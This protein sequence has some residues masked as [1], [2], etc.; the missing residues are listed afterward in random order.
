M[1]TSHQ[2]IAIQLPFFYTSR[3]DLPTAPVAI[4]KG[5]RILELSPTA[6]QAGAALHLPLR[7]LRLAIPDLHIVPYV[8]ATY[9]KAAAH[10]YQTC[11]LFSDAVEPL[12]PHYVLVSLARLDANAGNRL[13]QAVFS[14][15]NMPVVA[16]VA[17]T[18]WLARCVATHLAAQTRMILGKK[19]AKTPS[20]QLLTVSPPHAADFLASLP[21]HFLSESEIAKPAAIVQQLLCLG[22]QNFGQLAAIP[23][24]D[25][26]TRFGTTNGPLLQQLAQGIDPTPLRPMC[27]PKQACAAFQALPESEGISD[28]T[29]ADSILIHLSTQLAAILVG[30]AQ[31]ARTI[32]LYLTYR[33]RTESFQL[34]LSTPTMQ[35][36]ILLAAARRLWQRTNLTEPIFAIKLQAEKL[37]QPVVTQESIFLERKGTPGG[38]TQAMQSVHTRFGESALITA[39]QLPISRREM[40]RALWEEDHL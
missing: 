28:A 14:A 33:H 38:L 22:I 2:L 16:G 32:A 11:T 35:C 5:H 1:S 26:T 17:N 15:F 19:G 7:A 31:A 29:S 25:L 9:Q 37:E 40:V 30:R 6:L 39:G 3:P 13:L 4:V 18:R 12:L 8:A 34:Q 10:L 21:L 27:P 24:A 20:P 23:A 36:A